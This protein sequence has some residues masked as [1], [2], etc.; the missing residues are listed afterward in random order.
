MIQSTGLTSEQ[1]A[2][3]RAQYG[4]NVLTPPPR[5]PWWVQFKEK[6]DDPVIRILMIAAV[7]SFGVGLTDGHYVEGIGIV[8]AILLATGLAFINEFR[9]NK[10]FDVLNQTS[11]EAL[12]KVIRDGGHT[13]IP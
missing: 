5:D 8:V 4:E 3:S 2:T 12:V 6:F 10:E 11:D 1:V 9:A 13:T 7:I